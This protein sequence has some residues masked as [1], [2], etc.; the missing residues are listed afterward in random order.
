MNLTG[1]DNATIKR[2]RFLIIAMLLGFVIATTLTASDFIDYYN[3]GKTFD[4]EQMDCIYKS[5]AQQKNA[6]KKDFCDPFA[7]TEEESERL[8]QH[9]VNKQNYVEDIKDAYKTILLISLALGLSPF[10]WQFLL[11]R[12]YEVSKAI[13]GEKL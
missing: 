12:I 7:I 10:L 3:E 11:A 4:R 13:R 1:H 8:H 5:N 6:E 9:L 2:F